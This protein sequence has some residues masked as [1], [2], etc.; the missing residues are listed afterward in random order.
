MATTSGGSSPESS[1]SP[2]GLLSGHSVTPPRCTP[3]EFFLTTP[4]E[5]TIAT[6]PTVVLVMRERQ[7][8]SGPGP[9][10]RQNDVRRLSRSRRQL[11]NAV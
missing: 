8:S 6:V 11:Y 10:R 9:Q 4:P 1:S 2:E 5:V 7:E 3:R